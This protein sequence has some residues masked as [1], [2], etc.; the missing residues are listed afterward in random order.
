M[1]KFLRSI[2]SCLLLELIGDCVR[3]TYIEG[4]KIQY[5]AFAKQ[6][7]TIIF[8]SQDNLQDGVSLFDR[9]IAVSQI[10]TCLD[11]LCCYPTSDQIGSALRIDDPRRA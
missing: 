4:I 1:I 10:F 3:D 2:T 9:S 8:H 11:L 7:L 6:I 5:L